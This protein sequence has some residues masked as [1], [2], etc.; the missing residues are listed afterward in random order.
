VVK[1]ATIATRAASKWGGPMIK[2]NLSGL[3]S[4]R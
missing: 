1:G 3:L 4:P 2:L